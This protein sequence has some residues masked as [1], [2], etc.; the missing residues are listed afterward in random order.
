MTNEQIFAYYTG[1]AIITEPLS[2]IKS[3]KEA[4][5]WLCKG[6]SKAEELAGR[7]CEVAVK[8]Y[9]DI[10]QRSFRNMDTYLEGRIGRTIRKR[11][12]ILHVYASHTAMQA[13]WVD[14]EWCAL[15][16]LSEAGITVPMPFARTSDSVGME[17]IAC[18]E[19]PYEAAPRLREARLDKEGAE[20]ACHNLLSTIWNMLGCD[21]IHGDLSPYNVLVRN[22]K[23]VLIDFP[24]IVDARYHSLAYELLQRDIGN[25]MAFFEKQGIKIPESSGAMTSRLWRLYETNALY[26]GDYWREYEIKAEVSA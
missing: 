7:H 3:G 10:E 26:R 21:M 6:G 9:K 5:V 11:R 24:Q 18:A 17:F 13:T 23:P 22:G 1:E 2:E 20:V 16:D 25:I 19:D 12:D 4:T 8:I 15:Q 14:A